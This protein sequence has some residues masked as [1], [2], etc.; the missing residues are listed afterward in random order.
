MPH[1]DEALTRLRR[2]APTRAQ[3]GRSFA[4]LLHKALSRHDGA[5]GRRFKQLWRGA[6]WPGA[7]PAARAVDV[8]AEE[9][10]G[11][12]CAIHCTGGWAGRG[13]PVAVLTEF[14]AATAA[15]CFT[16]RVCVHTGDPLPDAALRRLARGGAPCRVLS[17][18]ELDAW[19]VDWRLPRR[20]LKWQPPVREMARPAQRDA[21]NEVLTHFWLH[22]RGRLALPGGPGRAVVSLW[23]AEGQVGVGGWVLALCPTLD[24]MTR[25]VRRW[26]SQAAL[27][28]RYLGVCTETELQAAETAAARW[29]LDI[30][31]RT[32]SVQVESALAQLHP[33]SMSVVFC[34]YAALGLVAA[35][36]AAGRATFSPVPVQCAGRYAPAAPRSPAV[37]GG[38]APVHNP[39]RD[40]RGRDQP[41]LP[42]WT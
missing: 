30:P 16:A 20:R 21:V 25:T 10:D 19:P 34:T 18:A 27:P 22:D 2:T 3:L 42:V 13:V 40:P 9:Y 26:G 12:L 23:I 38:Q 6:D 14:Q 35:A 5:L 28:Y 41:G 24:H 8:V 1:L 39:Q 32:D 15:P 7:D 31:P 37:A 36:Q 11:G 33:D 4:P 17:R 29:E